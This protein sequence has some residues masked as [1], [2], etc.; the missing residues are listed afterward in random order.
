MIMKDSDF[1]DMITGKIGAQKVSDQVWPNPPK[2]NLIIALLWLYMGNLDSLQLM[3]S[4]I[5]VC[6]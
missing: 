2:N 4:F 1:I 6:L 3:P 5:D